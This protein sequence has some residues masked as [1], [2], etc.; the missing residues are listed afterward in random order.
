MKARGAQADTAKAS[1]REIVKIGWPRRARAGTPR[2]SLVSRKKTP[3]VAN[4]RQGEAELHEDKEDDGDPTGASS[5]GP[6][7]DVYKGTAG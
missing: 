1:Y 7:E 5:A 2:M 4:Q 3:T 6:P